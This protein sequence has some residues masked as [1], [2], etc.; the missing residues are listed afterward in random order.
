[1]P[2]MS[3]KEK[4]FQEAWDKYKDATGD[5]MN[6]ESQ[7][8]WGQRA[9]GSWDSNYSSWQHAINSFV[10]WLSGNGGSTEQ[11]RFPDLTVTQSGAT[12][13]VDLKFT[14]S[15]GTVDTWRD[16]LGKGNG[17]TQQQDYNSI[18][19][20]Q[21]GGR[22]PYPNDDPSLDPEKCGCGKGTKVQQEVVPQRVPAGSPFFVMPGVPAPGGLPG[23]VPAP[24]AMPV[25]E[26]VPI[27]EGIPVFP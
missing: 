15:D 6:I 11:V 13:V 22:N 25:P 17:S 23:A 27:F 19:K 4:C 9:D 20:Q 16:Q 26:P 24:G 7:K 8:P 2:G 21:N 14:R 5:D 1:M 10:K 12:S 18:N 3:A